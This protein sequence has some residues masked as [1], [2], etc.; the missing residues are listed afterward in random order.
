M[1]RYGNLCNRFF[2]KRIY[3]AGSR[4]PRLIRNQQVDGSNPPAAQEAPNP[5]QIQG[6]LFSRRGSLDCRYK[7]GWL[8]IV[9]DQA[10]ALVGNGEYLS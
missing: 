2:R 9:V 5:I 6:F 3:S 8:E 7:S 1:T 10:V 4:N